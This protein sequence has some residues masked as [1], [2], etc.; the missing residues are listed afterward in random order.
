MVS[1]INE[2]HAELSKSIQANESQNNFNSMLELRQKINERA[3][4]LS[5]PELVEL[6]QKRN[7]RAGTLSNPELAK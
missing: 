3:V 7:E 2:D 5:N 4:T 1:D 6:R